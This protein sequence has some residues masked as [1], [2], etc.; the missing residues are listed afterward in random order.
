MDTIL[1]ID[2]L[3]K[4]EL[5]TK[6][7]L[8]YY[9]NVW[10]RNLIART[11][12]VDCDKVL[13]ESN[14]A[15]MVRTDDQSRFV[16]VLERLELRKIALADCLKLNASIDRL[17]AMDSLDASYWSPEALKVSDEMMKATEEVAPT[18]S[19]EVAAEAV[20]TEEVA[21]PAEMPDTI[22]EPESTSSPE[23]QQ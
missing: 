5:S 2:A 17:L 4:K 14:P 18:V 13:L 23:T 11:I 22:P 3:S 20:A 1:S 10:Q 8:T 9:K 21:A 16:P 19:E 12:D 6:E 7:W 15:E